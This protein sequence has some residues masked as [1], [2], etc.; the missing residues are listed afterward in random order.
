MNGAQDAAPNWRDSKEKRATLPT[1]AEAATPSSDKALREDD[2]MLPAI[3]RSAEQRRLDVRHTAAQHGRKAHPA[4]AGENA[5]D[6]YQQID[7]MEEYENCPYCNNEYSISTGACSTC[8]NCTCTDCSHD[9]D[10]GADVVKADEGGKEQQSFGHSIAAN[11]WNY[12]NSDKRS[13]EDNDDEEAAAAEEED[14]DDDHS[15]LSA[16]ESVINLLNEVHQAAAAATAATPSPTEKPLSPEHNLRRQ[17]KEAFGRSANSPVSSGSNHVVVMANFCDQPEAAA[18]ASKKQLLPILPTDFLSDYASRK[19]LGGGGDG[20][21]L[22]REGETVRLTEEMF[23]GARDDAVVT[24][25][26]VRKQH[27]SQV[28]LP[29]SIRVTREN[30][31]PSATR[32]DFDFVNSSLTRRP[33]RTGRTPGGR[34]ARSRRRRRRGCPGRR[35]ATAASRRRRPSAPRPAS[36]CPRGRRSPRRTPGWRAS[37]SRRRRFPWGGSP[38][39][40]ESSQERS[41]G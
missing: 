40:P 30:S 16:A 8:D 15:S 1:I 24:K 12:L 28:R 34:R 32:I 35:W 13:D 7:S 26:V 33:R 9:G 11:S 3:L 17:L 29:M 2:E 31:N 37:S 4:A 41:R 39:S 14:D 19:E 18:S 20:A 21:V 36:P 27:L 10:M 22:L 6:E 25:S 38:C 23:R 5:D